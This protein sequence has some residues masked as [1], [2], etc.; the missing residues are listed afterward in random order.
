[1]RKLGEKNKIL[2]TI[3]VVIII[4]IILIFVY[5]IGK[6]SDY[7][8]QKYNVKIGSILYDEDFNY[9]TVKGEEAYIDQQ[10]DGKYYLIDKYDNK[11]YKTKI[12]KTAISY[13]KEDYQIY[14]YGKIYQVLSSGDIVSLYGQTKIAKTSPTKFYKLK[15][16]KYLFVDDSIKTTDNTINTSG[17]VIIELDRQ[18]N[19]TFANQELNIKTINP[20][21]LKGSLFNF[22]IAHEQLIYEKETINL[23][24]IIG[25]TNLYKDKEDKQ[26]KKD[27]KNQTNKEDDNKSYYDD[28]LRNVINSFNNLTSNVGGVNEK[29]KN[30]L[31]KGEIYYDFSK[32]IALKKVSTT[33]TTITL[34]YAV[35]DPNNEYQVVFVD[36]K[37]ENG[38][39]GKVY[40]NKKDSSYII[41]NLDTNKKYTV[42]LGYQLTGSEKEVYEDVVEVQTK[43]PDYSIKITKVTK[44]RIYY[45]LKIDNYYKL[46][47][48]TVKLYIDGQEIST[49]FVNINQAT[50]AKGYTGSLTYN[51]LGNI[52]EVKLQ[53]MV[54][55]GDEIILNVSD[56]FINE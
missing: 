35:Y 39:G 13:N 45:N 49:E 50:T 34:D 54:Y 30:T 15:D 10:Y 47:Q 12:G 11:T 41:R 5:F 3:L 55:N 51:K 43:I 44:D 4:I 52:N 32:W 16:R 46:D 38:I 22:D 2:F 7:D 40:L 56:K 27:D 48:A 19:A 20:L 33:A 23:K 9:V 18:G 29:T 25:S 21:V 31:K 37:D 26:E 6:F 8:D 53:D 17:Y 24:N 14:V 1:M 28:Y 42:S 36:I